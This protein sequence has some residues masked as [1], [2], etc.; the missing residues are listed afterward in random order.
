ME[1]VAEGP[2]KEVGTGK[3]RDGEIEMRR[4]AG[5]AMEKRE[6]EREKKGKD[7]TGREDSEGIEYK[8]RKERKT[9]EKTED[10]RPRR[11]ED[12]GRIRLQE[13]PNF[14]TTIDHS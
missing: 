6:R 13:Q 14:K 8:R 12:R 4:G 7:Q 2:L 9:R 3:E 5:K 1:N 11:M 10:T